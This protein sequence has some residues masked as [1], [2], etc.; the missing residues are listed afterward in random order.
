MTVMARCHSRPMNDGVKVV[1]L[2]FSFDIWL[3]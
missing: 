2:E 1:G 3:V